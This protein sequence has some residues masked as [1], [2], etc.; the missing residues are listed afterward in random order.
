MTEATVRRKA[1]SML[2]NPLE[3]QHSPTDVINKLLDQGINMP[4]GMF[5]ASSPNMAK[6]MLRQCQRRRV[7]LPD[8]ET[9]VIY[10]GNLAQ[11]PDY[12]LPDGTVL[13]VHQAAPTGITE[14]AEA[15]PLGRL[16]V[17]VY[18]R[19]HLALI[20]SGSMISVISDRLRKE[21]GLIST[22]R[23]GDFIRGIGG[24]LVPMAGICTDVEILI[25]GVPIKNHLMVSTTAAVNLL[26][27]LPFLHAVKANLDYTDSGGTLLTMKIG[28]K[29]LEAMLRR[30]GSVQKRIKT[31]VDDWN[32]G[33][34]QGN[35]S[36]RV[37]PNLA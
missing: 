35:S 33:E 32:T 9:R 28:P 12:T 37:L 17:M 7:P 21:L 23:E 6:A 5:L 34:W 30:T 15:H 29:T 1:T 19:E 3:L 25:G 13:E 36:E 11:M 31:D 16:P 27:G 24:H 18:G 26:I 14:A 4:L 20:D 8:D 2:K 22:K 10:D